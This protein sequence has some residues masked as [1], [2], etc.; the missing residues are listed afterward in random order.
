MPIMGTQTDKI[1]C[2]RNGNS[3]VLSMI[4]K[5][6]YEK[7]KERRAIHESWTICWKKETKE[8]KKVFL[9]QLVPE[10]WVY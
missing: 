7:E 4:I 5:K 8:I 2:S 10:L 6:I 1:P 9:A 3:S